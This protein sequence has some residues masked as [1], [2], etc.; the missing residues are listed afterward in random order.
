MADPG[1]EENAPKNFLVNVGPFVGKNK[2]RGLV[3]LKKIKKSEKNSDCPDFF[4]LKMYNEKNNTKNT[5][6]PKKKEIRVGA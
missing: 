5:I 1:S 3:E 4:F 6:F 2:V